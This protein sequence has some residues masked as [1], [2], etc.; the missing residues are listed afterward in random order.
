MKDWFDDAEQ[1]RQAE[2]ALT[3]YVYETRKDG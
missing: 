3:L 1:I 2:L